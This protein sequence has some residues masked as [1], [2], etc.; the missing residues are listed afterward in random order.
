[1]VVLSS[2]DIPPTVPVHDFAIVIDFRKGESSPTRV[3][4]AAS[5]MIN[6]LE[7][8][9]QTL[10]KSIHSS[11]EPTM[12]LE[13]VE[14]GSLKIWLKNALRATDDQALK[15]INWKSAVG[16]YLVRGK[17]LIL[18]WLEDESAAPKSIPDLRRELQSLAQETDVLKMPTYTPPETGE[19]IESM[20]YI[21][22]A[23]DF[24]GPTDRIRY[25]ANVEDAEVVDIKTPVNIEELADLATKE[26][27]N[28]PP[29]PMI[30]A[31]K[32]PDYLGTSKWDFKHGKKTISAKITDDVF[33]RLFQGREIDVRPG[34]L[35]KCLVAAELR[36]GFDNSLISERYTVTSVEDV[37][38]GPPPQPGLFDDPD[39][40]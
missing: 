10:A 1:M 3:F 15:E 5:A 29:G 33:L 35:L 22:K 12:L 27:F 13:D 6:A 8:L 40:T 16:K 19:L 34:D 2:T 17:Y 26:V 36:Y 23:Q 4:S 37:L 39:E 11:I 9:D 20:G 32:R 38:P 30:L 31:V 7:R 28:T 14:V 18:R 25:E 21:R 24:L